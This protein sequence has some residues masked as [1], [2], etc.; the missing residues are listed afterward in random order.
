MHGVIEQNFYERELGAAVVSTRPAVSK[1]RTEANQLVEAEYRPWQLQ[2]KVLFVTCLEG[3][4]QVLVHRFYAAVFV[5]PG[6]LFVIA[7]FS[8]CGKVCFATLDA[9]ACFYN[10]LYIS[11]ASPTTCRCWV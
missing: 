11:Y 6:P 2:C 5:A 10:F 8:A 3:H 4:I 1:P 7:R 9:L